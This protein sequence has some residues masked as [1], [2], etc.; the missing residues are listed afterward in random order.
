MSLLPFVSSPHFFE[1]HDPSIL[2]SVLLFSVCL[3]V[4]H[5]IID[6]LAHK[7]SSASVHAIILV[8]FLVCVCRTHPI[9][10][11]LVFLNT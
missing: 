3:L 9:G 5:L 4:T 11:V 2:C 6:D 7:P 8:D 10:G 1:T